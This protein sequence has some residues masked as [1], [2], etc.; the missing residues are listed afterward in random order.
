MRRVLS[1]VCAA[2]FAADMAVRFLLS[3]MPR[4][5]RW[6]IHHILCFAFTC[7]PPKMTFLLCCHRLHLLFLLLVHAGLCPINTA[8][9]DT[10]GKR[11]GKDAPRRSP[12]FGAVGVD[13][14]AEDPAPKPTS[15]F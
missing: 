13:W 4:P 2:P 15:S 7:V 10:A 5:L 1:V 14:L 6:E 3:V 9:R 12:G 11:G 8:R